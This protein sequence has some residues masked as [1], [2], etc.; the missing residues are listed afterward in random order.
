MEGGSDA[1]VKV[2]SLVFDAMETLSRGDYHSALQ[3][4]EE[5]NEMCEKLIPFYSGTNLATLE[6]IKK[7]CETQS[8]QIQQYIESSDDIN[9]TESQYLSG[10]SSVYRESDL[11]DTSM[12]FPALNKREEI[13]DDST[14]DTYWGGYLW[15]KV[16]TLLQMLHPHTDQLFQK[17]QPEMIP[18]KREEITLDSSFILLP[19][20]GSGQRVILNEP[21]KSADPNEKIKE[22]E[23]KNA[24]L[25]NQLE[26]MKKIIQPQGVTNLMNE[27]TKLKRSIIDFSNYVQ[28]HRNLGKTQVSHGDSLVG[29][30]S[31]E[32]EDQIRELILKVAILEKE[33]LRKDKEIREL[34]DYKEKW[35]NLKK[36]ASAR[37][38]QKESFVRTSG[39]SESF[40]NNLE[41]K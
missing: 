10:D 15:D 38:K 23:S 8:N 21:V 39:A 37:K 31:K 30:T 27:N 18:V 11:G 24:L 28:K 6:G 13:N 26:Q 9:L 5:G 29:R 20:E 41:Q 17:F 1:I 14:I 35:L 40:A 3:K 25:R 33:N 34:M 7:S 2:Q 16:E 22:L 32:M 36:E 12:L 19:N 4:F